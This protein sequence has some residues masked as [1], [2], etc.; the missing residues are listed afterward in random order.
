MWQILMY[1]ILSSAFLLCMWKMNFLSSQVWRMSAM[2]VC[3][4][5]LKNKVYRMNEKTVHASNTILCTKTSRKYSKRLKKKTFWD[6]FSTRT[7]ITRNKILKKS[8]KRIFKF[9][10]QSFLKTWKSKGFSIDVPLKYRYKNM[11]ENRTVFRRKCLDEL[12][13]IRWQ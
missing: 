7:K 6:S 9:L 13:V 12:E 1:E 5:T 2:S 10:S 3:S 11:R 4:K 8:A